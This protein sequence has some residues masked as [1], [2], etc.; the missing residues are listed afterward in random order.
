L[1][2]IFDEKAQNQKKTKKRKTV[3]WAAE[4]A[5]FQT[6]EG[7]IVVLEEEKEKAAPIEEKKN[8]VKVG[9]RSKMTLG[10]VVNGTPAPKRKM[11]GRS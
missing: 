9:V 6:E 10:M 4:L 2:E 3:V 5:Q 7:K 8:A 11:R 1:K